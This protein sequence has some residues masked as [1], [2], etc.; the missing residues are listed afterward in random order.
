[1]RVWDAL[2]GAELKILNGH[3][4]IVL[5]ISLS[6]DGTRVGPGS[7]DNSVRVWDASTGAELKILNGHTEVLRPS[8]FRV[9][10]DALSL[11]RGTCLCGYEIPR[12][13]RSSGP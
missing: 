5:S 6:T 12:R 8:R 9:M 7:Y 1:M 3:T 13:A 2:T 11:V 4:D 10:A